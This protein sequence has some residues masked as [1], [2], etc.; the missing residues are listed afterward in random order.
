MK[1][2][3]KQTTITSKLP[4]GQYTQTGKGTLKEVFR[5]HFPDSKLIED[6]DDGQR[7]EKLGICGRIT[8][9]GDWNM[10]KCVVNQSKIRWALGTFKPHKSSGTDGIV[11]AFLQQGM[12][13]LVPQ[14]C[15]I[16]RA[17]M[18]YGSIPTAWRQVKVTFVPQPGQLDYTEAKTYRPISLSS[19]LLKRWRN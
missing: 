6:S 18:A 8:N 9:R 2:M 1:I 5:V 16:F 4:D 3:A 14:L 17:C 13:H 19:F 11:P 12:E 15:R 10:A 7:Q